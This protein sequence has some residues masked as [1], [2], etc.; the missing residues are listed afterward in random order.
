[1]TIPSFGF[2]RRLAALFFDRGLRDSRIHLLPIRTPITCR[3]KNS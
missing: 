1:M 2:S 3:F